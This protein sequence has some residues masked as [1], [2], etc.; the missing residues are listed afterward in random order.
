MHVDHVVP[1]AI[2]LDGYDRLDNLVTLCP[3]DHARKTLVDRSEY[4]FKV[5]NKGKAYSPEEKSKLNISGLSMGRHWAKGKSFSD[6]H[7]RSLSDAHKGQAGFWTGKTFT[8]E[9]RRNLSNSHK[10]KTPW[11][12]GV[13]K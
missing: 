1:R 6:E 3:N 13:S 7:R 8:E 9:H 5:W 11:N 12:K 2:V 4:S 10:G